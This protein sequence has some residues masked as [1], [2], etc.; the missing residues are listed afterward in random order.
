[1]LFG[2]KNR[3]KDEAKNENSEGAVGNLDYEEDMNSQSHDLVGEVNESST[4][5]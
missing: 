5:G 4:D 3:V 2:G 1:M